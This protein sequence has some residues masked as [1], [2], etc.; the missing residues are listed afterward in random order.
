MN[1]GNRI[2]NNFPAVFVLFVAGLLFHPANTYSQSDSQKV[3]QVLPRAIPQ[4]AGFDVI[5]KINGDI[6]YGLV[7][8]VGPY[9]VS[10]QR[11]DIPDGPVYTIPRNEV[12]V[13]SYRNQVK[14]YINSEDVVGDAPSLNDPYLLNNEPRRGRYINYKNKDLFKKGS[15]RVALGFLKSF[16]KVENSKDYSTSGSFP[17]VSL[18]YEVNYKSNILLGVQ[19]GFGSHNFSKEEYSS[20]DSTKTGVTL[21]ENI[22]GLYVYGRYYFLDSSSRLRPFILGGIGIVSSNVHENNTIRFTNDNTQVILVKSGTRKTG[23]GITARVG[24]DYFISNHM[25]LFADA[26]AGLSVIN[27]GLA[28]SI[29]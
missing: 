14:D 21:K 29:K 18:G 11:T 9:Y 7:K 5:V 28:F 24:A 22:F 15:V 27:V 20:Y 2:L 25:Q 4:N 13:I 17:A 3:T 6:V 19:I 8:E 1:N 23:L 10:Y 16:S 12:Y 26:G